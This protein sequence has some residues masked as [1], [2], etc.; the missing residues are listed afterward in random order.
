MSCYEHLQSFF[1][2]SGSSFGREEMKNKLLSGFNRLKDASSKKRDLFK[3]K[4]RS[5]TLH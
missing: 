1:H 2:S 3:K 5:S 4:D